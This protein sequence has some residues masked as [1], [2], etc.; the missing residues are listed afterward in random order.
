MRSILLGVL[1][2][3]WGLQAI[4]ENKLAL[5]IGNG[6]YAPPANLSDLTADTESIANSLL[7]LGFDVLFYTDLPAAEMR[8]T[9]GEFS[10]SLDGVDVALFYFAG[11]ALQL[12]GRNFLIPTDANLRNEADIELSTIP[13]DVVISQMERLAQT[14]VIFLDTCHDNPFQA[15]IAARIGEARSAEVLGDCLAPIETAGATYVGLANA[16]G[17]LEAALAAPTAP[18]PVVCEICPSTVLVPG[19]RFTMG[20]AEGGPEEQPE[21]DVT[22]APF[23]MAVSEVTVGDIRRFEARTGQKIARSCY[24]WTEDGRLRS[25][26]G[27]YWGTPGYDVSDSSPA[28]CL[29]WDD[30]QGYIAWLNDSDP[31]GGWRL[32]SEAEFE[33]AARAGTQ[34]P[35]PWNGTICRFVNGA[36]VSSQFR[37]RNTSCDDGAPT[38]TA[39]GVFPA[40]AFSLYDL[41]GN[42]WEWTEDCW[43]GSHRGATSNGRA[44]AEGTCNSRVLRGGSW[45]DPKENLRSSYRVGIPKSRRQANVGFR[46]VRDTD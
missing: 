43:N 1:F 42:L 2:T 3:I 41:I 44:R 23:H 10:D 9:I 13:L 20:S 36:D 15:T 33:F 25:R 6:A 28:S 38:P 29:S 17:A 12:A 4:A 39:A 18:A 16:P 32:P 35:Y 26:T 21:T 30:A 19:G 34:A 8:R 22:I 5:V 27:A 31:R 24:V 46:P 11:H 40:N 7:E 45:D 14:R 37:W